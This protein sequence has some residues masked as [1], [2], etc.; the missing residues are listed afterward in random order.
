MHYEGIIAA[1]LGVALGG[2]GFRF[3]SK[4]IGPN[5]TKT[6]VEYQLEALKAAYDRISELEARVITLE[7]AVARM[8]GGELPPQ[9]A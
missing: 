3:W 9:P 8:S 6:I 2:G 7:G 5:R 1:L 4:L